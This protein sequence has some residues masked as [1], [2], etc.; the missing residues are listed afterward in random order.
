MDSKESN[1]VMARKTSKNTVMAKFRT[2]LNELMTYIEQTSVRYIRCIKPNSDMKPRIMNHRHTMNQLESAGLVTAITIS[3][4][5]FPN[6]YVCR[7]I[8]KHFFYLISER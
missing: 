3:R 7:K 2:Q 5:T 1:A 6:R 8:F 4:E